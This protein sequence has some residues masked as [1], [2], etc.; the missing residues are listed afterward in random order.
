MKENQGLREYI[1]RLGL[2]PGCLSTITE[3]YNQMAGRIWVIENSYAMKKKDSHLIITAANLEKIDKTDGVSRWSELSQCIDFHTKM[4][5]QCRIPSK[6]WLVNEPEGDL[7]KR[8]SLGWGK[9]EEISR[10]SERVT[11]VMKDAKLDSKANQ[12]ARQLRNIEKYVSK[13]AS[14]LMGKDKFIGVVVCTQGE[15]TDKKGDKGKDVLRDFLKSLASLSDLPVKTVFRLC[16]DNDLVLDFY[17]TLD[18]NE[19]CDV[20]DDFWGEVRD[21]TR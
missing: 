19:K 13:E 20:L 5:A 17:N 4:A 12:L 1:E 8:F 9:G 15:P 18:V 7:P 2:P 14:I 16:T 6:Y 3:M 11:Q 10:E 21:I